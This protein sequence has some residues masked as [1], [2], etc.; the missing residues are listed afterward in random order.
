MRWAGLIGAGTCMSLTSLVVLLV[1][2]AA[3]R[4]LWGS[5]PRG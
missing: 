2:L 3:S 1:A 4:F 5:N